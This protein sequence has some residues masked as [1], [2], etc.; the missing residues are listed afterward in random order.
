VRPRQVVS[1]FEA[2]SG[3]A[4]TT[5]GVIVR[6][7]AMRVLY[8]EA[9]RAAQAPITLLILGETGVGK[10]VL[11][12]AVHARSP[13]AKKAFLGVNCAAFS[14]TLLESELFGPEQGAFTGAH[15][16]HPGIFE[17]TAGGTVFLD[18]VGEMSQA[19]QAKLLRVLEERT[20]MRLG[21]R[22]PKAID[23]RFIAATN[24]DLEADV[25]TGRFRQ[26]LYFRLNG[27]CLTIPPL[28]ER[29][30]EIQPLVQRFLA[31]ACVQL[32]GPPP[33]FSAE[34]L[35]ALERYAWPGNVRELRNVV[36]RA[37]VLCNGTS[38]EVRHLP[39]SLL[40]A[41]GRPSATMA[42]AAPATETAKPSAATLP[43]GLRTN[44][45]EERR[46]LERARVIDALERCSGNQTRAAEMLG[47]SRRT[48]VSWL[49]EFGISRPRKP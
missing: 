1:H 42:S 31:T 2:L 33:K 27:L 10:E 29:P 12:R 36:E 49:D 35:A 6:D 24:R 37:V 25:R 14:E 32:G 48:L 11:A 26:D 43:P 20:V 45:P 34:A 17:A 47:I 3:E 5:G 44:L 38:I 41:L 16:A 13:R 40:A 22:S 39:P 46:A 4:G 23:V 7:P 21:A 28:R 18:E 15:R 8:A 30:E 19:T 9:E